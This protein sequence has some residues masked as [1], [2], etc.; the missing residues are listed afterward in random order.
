[1][2]AMDLT[3]TPPHSQEAEQVVIG[4]M[5]AA[6][7]LI[8]DVGNVIVPDD[9]YDP[10]HATIMETLSWLADEARPVEVAS[11]VTRLRDQGELD[12]IGGTEYIVRLFRQASPHNAM[13]YTEVIAEKSAKRQIMNLHMKGMRNAQDGNGLDLKTLVGETQVALDTITE[14][15]VSNEVVR[16]GHVLSGTIDKIEELGKSKGGITGIPTGFY[17]LDRMTYGLHPGQMIV[18]AARPGVGKSTL[19]LDFVRNAAIR[20][21]VPSMLFSL[22]MSVDE[23]NMRLLSA[24][25]MVELNHIRSGRVTDNEWDR[26][27]R[28]QQSIMDA[29]LFFDDTASNTMSQIRQKARRIQQRHGL[30]LIVIDYLQ[31]M[32]GDRR[33]DSRQQEVSEISRAIKLLAKEMKIPVVAMS[34][35]N[36]GSESRQDNRP[37]VS[38]LRESGSI[39]Q[40]A[41]VV[42]LIHREDMYDPETVRAGEADIIIGK[43]RSAPQ[44]TAVLGWQ[45]GFSRFADM[46][47]EEEPY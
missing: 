30:G 2:T 25:A 36:R 40:D 34:Q 29:P 46:T 47:R 4:S 45:G 9:F 6:P 13:Y 35:L 20:H 17:E 18:I 38:D 44:G 12:K 31:L 11:L 32:Q 3:T 23:I 33:V 8:A 5:I 26:I 24:E 41:D 21:G 42:M 27:A 39:E 1:M 22:E 14:K 16:A 7:P 43:Q 19:G 10:R 28:K 15:R 37:K